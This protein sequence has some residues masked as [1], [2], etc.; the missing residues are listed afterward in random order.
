[1]STLPTL[2]DQLDDPQKRF[3]AALLL[4]QLHYQP[5]LPRLLAFLTD[6]DRAIRWAA[7]YALGL[8]SDESAIPTLIPL[9]KE[10]D[11]WMRLA[12]ARALGNLY[13]QEATAQLNELLAD[14]ETMVQ[15]A[16][17][18]AL[19]MIEQP[20]YER[21]VDPQ[22]YQTDVL[23]W[24]MD[25]MNRV[26]GTERGFIALKDQA[27]GNLEYQTSSGIG[28]QTTK[29]ELVA[30]NTSLIDEVLTNKKPIIT[31]N[32]ATDARFQA[33]SSIIM[34]GL[35]SVIAVPLMVNDEVVGVIYGDNPI[36]KGL[37]NTDQLEAVR[38]LAEQAA[39]ALVVPHMAAPPEGQAQAEAP[40]LE[41][42]PPE[43]LPG[44]PESERGGRAA[45]DAEETGSE[46]QFSAYYPPESQINRRHGL[47]VYAHVADAFNAIGQ[48]VQRFREEL[49][50]A[51]RAPKKAKQT[52]LLKTDTPITITPECDE[53]EF[54]PPTLTK[55]WHEDFVRF[56]FDFRPSTKLVGESLLVRISV[57]VGAV[58]IVHISVP[59]EIVEELAQPAEVPDQNPLAAAKLSCKT[60]AIYQRI[61]ISYS[62]KDQLVA[63]NYRLAQMALG[64][65]VFM[66][67]YSIRA[68]E[69]WRAALA[70]AIDDADI[71]QLFWSPH[72]AGSENVRDEWDYA[73]K[74]KCPDT[75]CDSFIRPVFWV[76]PMPQPPNELSHLNFH[77][78]PLGGEGHP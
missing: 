60:A 26:A 35:R 78:V 50:G 62:R 39:T 45:D 23:N 58:E 75:R 40:Q 2:L 59:L 43:M 32:A 69:D 25:A 16:A 7:T 56:D 64:N 33:G 1:M 47:F 28:E 3:S 68:G 52:A 31:N 13:A 24:L 41:E 5:A 76:K 20:Q 11:R 18:Q 73:L 55:K 6:S 63:E 34:R 67:S 22:Q 54:E 17:A 9:L 15:I 51:V 37:A 19:R 21:T 53:L 65:Q 36:K 38:V 10:D 12:A 66:D 29:D 4:G 57:Q 61:F 42:A 49:G 30:E 44:E 27:T 74:H 70:R 8:L 14:P 48:D 72:S 46:V 77:F 71:F